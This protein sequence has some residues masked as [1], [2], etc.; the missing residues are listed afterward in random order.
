MWFVLHISKAP[1]YFWRQAGTLLF[2]G[3]ELI[4]FEGGI[5]DVRTSRKMRDDRRMIKHGNTRG[6]NYNEKFKK[7]RLAS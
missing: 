1:E 3:L 6:F 4:D 7:L 2:S 5:C